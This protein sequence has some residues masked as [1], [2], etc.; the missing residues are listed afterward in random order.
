M[1]SQWLGAL[2]P[3]PGV[4]PDFV[5][6]PTQRD[7]NIALHTVLLSLVTILVV[8]RLYT[9]VWVTKV[10][11]GIEDYLCVVSYLLSVTFSGLVIKAYTR[12]IGRHIWDTPAPWL[13][14]ALMYFTISTWVYL[15]LGATVKLT[16]LSFYHRLFST[17]ILEI[18]RHWRNNIRRTFK[19]LINL[20]HRFQLHAGVA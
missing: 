13:P 6:P 18:L 1:A 14:E 9:R 11:L 4:T 19:R 2:P 12:G 16:F 8:L 17:H 3:P 20:C 7:G 5:D 15:I 10:P